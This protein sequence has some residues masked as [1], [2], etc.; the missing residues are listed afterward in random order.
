MECSYYRKAKFLKRF[1]GIQG[2]CTFHKIDIKICNKASYYPYICCK[3]A[4]GEEFNNCAV[5]LRI[6]VQGK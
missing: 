2:Y 1:I 3:G 6:T 4:K 5:Q